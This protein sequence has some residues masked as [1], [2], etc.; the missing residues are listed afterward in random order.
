[1]RKSTNNIQLGRPPTQKKKFCATS[2]G[3]GFSSFMGHI[4]HEKSHVPRKSI[5]AH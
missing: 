4:I 5:S 1:M 3:R 2:P